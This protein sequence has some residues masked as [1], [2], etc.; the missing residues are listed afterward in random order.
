MERIR[1]LGKHTEHAGAADLR[2][3]RR[4]TAE[5]G[6]VDRIPAEN[7]NVP[8]PTSREGWD[9]VGHGRRSM[10]LRFPAECGPD[11]WI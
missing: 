9:I 2:A 3:R 6:G 8:C 4:R 5:N 7:G 11:E 1:F 10:L